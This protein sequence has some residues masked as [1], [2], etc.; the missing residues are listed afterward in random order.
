[1]IELIGLQA[2]ILNNNVL[3]TGRGVWERQRF[4]MM[5]EAE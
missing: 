1:M 5:T 4:N 3:I 2:D